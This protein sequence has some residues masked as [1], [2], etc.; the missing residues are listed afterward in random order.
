MEDTSTSSWRKGDVVE[1]LV[2]TITWP[3]AGNQQRADLL[4]ENE[5]NVLLFAA[6]CCYEGFVFIVDLEMQ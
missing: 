2:A 1:P 3:P 6:Q 5:D 4:A